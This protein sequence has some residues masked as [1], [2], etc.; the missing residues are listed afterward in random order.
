M[1][2]LDAVVVAK[3]LKIVSQKGN[4]LYNFGSL[5]KPAKSILI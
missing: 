5:E 3:T 4:Y 2:S 1:K